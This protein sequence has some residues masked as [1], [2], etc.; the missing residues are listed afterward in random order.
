[1]ESTLLPQ[2][3]PPGTLLPPGVPPGYPYPPL[4][5]RTMPPAPDLSK[6]FPVQ[7]AKFSVY[8]AI[9]AFLINFVT[10]QGGRGM[11]RAWSA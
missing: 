3:M 8:S 9:F 7:A 5:Q 10:V 2:G 6:A 11:P 4:R 1:M